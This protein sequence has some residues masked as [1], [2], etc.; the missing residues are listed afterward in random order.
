MNIIKNFYIIIFKNKKMDTN[1]NNTDNIIDSLSYKSN[2]K[3]KGIIINT[4]YEM[5]YGNYKKRLVKEIFSQ[6]DEIFKIFD[7]ELNENIVKVYILI[8]KNKIP[9][10]ILNELL[11][12]Y[13]FLSDLKNLEYIDQFEF[14]GIIIDLLKIK[15]SLEKISEFL[16]T[17]QNQNLGV[18]SLINWNIITDKFDKIINVIGNNN[19][20]LKTFLLI[21][22]YDINLIKIHHEDIKLLV[23][24]LAD[25]L[26]FDF[27]MYYS[28]SKI[29]KYL[30]NK[31][32]VDLKNISSQSNNCVVLII[33]YKKYFIEQYKIKH[34]LFS[35]IY[36]DIKISNLSKYK[37]IKKNKY[38]DELFLDIKLVDSSYKI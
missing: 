11:V 21:D 25:S 5:E 26:A 8:L 28:S 6:L 33:K 36:Y 2:S 3:N 23:R 32:F 13:E 20:I 15:K 27:F 9:D 16:R 22:S 38:F 12:F 31:M 35:E 29:F 4:N 18:F 24:K 30:Y 37:Y 34:E 17:K 7:E 10:I 14:I 1:I 19:I